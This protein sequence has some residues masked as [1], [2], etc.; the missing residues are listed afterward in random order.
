[1]LRLVNALAPSRGDADLTRELA[2]HEAL[3]R[4]DLAI[5]PAE[6]PPERIGVAIDEPCETLADFCCRSAR[7]LSALRPSGGQ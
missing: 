2:A 5:R 4:N 3:M 6:A 7:S 1:V